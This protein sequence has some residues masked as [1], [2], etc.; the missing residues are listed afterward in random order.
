MSV[1][2]LLRNL[3]LCE[4][5]APAP[6]GVREGDAFARMDGEIRKLTDIYSDGPVDWSVVATQG[7]QILREE[8]KDLAVGVWLVVA[9]LNTAELAGLA[10]G[11]HVL[12][13]LVAQ[14]WATMSPPVGRLRA[15]RNLVEWLFG[16]IEEGV[17]GEMLASASPLQFDVHAELVSDWNV[18]DAF[19]REHDAEA[20][21][22]F[23]L[24]RLLAGL[25]VI[26][27][28]PEAGAENAAA[29]SSASGAVQVDER[30]PSALSVAAN[31]AQ[32]ALPA[33]IVAVPDSTDAAQLEQAAE[34]AVRS[35]GPLLDVCFTSA[36]SQAFA[37]R[38]NCAAAW[39][40]VDA[41]PLAVDGLTRIPPPPDAQRSALAQLI[42]TGTPF[43][44]AHY[45]QSRLAAFPF[46]L[47]LCRH[48]HAALVAAGAQAAAAAVAAEVQSFIARLRGVSELQFAD[49]MPFADSGTRAW[50]AT[51]TA[52]ATTGSADGEIGPAA[53]AWTRFFADARAQAAR[54]Q[55]DEALH[56]LDRQYAGAA[57]ARDR[58]RVRL[59]QCELVRDFGD[60]GTLGP[61]VVPLV[62]QVETYGLAQWEPE[63]A[64]DV[65][66]IAATVS[67]GHDN[68]EQ[69]RLLSNLAALDFAAAWRLNGL[70]TPQ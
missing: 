34:Q 4:I 25:P 48:S 40:F 58:L 61:L 18:I 39:A 29:S 23:R 9:W 20:P 59:T 45:T 15:R 2:P 62:H 24:Q 7:Q 17:T 21:A 31:S 70:R 16:K 56:S 19:W 63:L 35:L 11:V 52:L 55:L 3:G 41:V 50:L 28:P 12:R 30:S 47:D 6:A 49:G 57:A 37:Y 38:L 43:A 68:H 36:P 13:D 5:V 26:A 53:D 33:L 1:D 46:W 67:G 42:A 60:A 14:H 51:L 44:V 65:L 64:R 10:A 27:P 32:P 8:G 66:K 69:N 22:F 54:G